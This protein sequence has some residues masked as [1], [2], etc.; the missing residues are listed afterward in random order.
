VVVASDGN[1]AARRLRDGTSYALVLL[2][3]MMPK[4]TGYQLLPIARAT[5]PKARVMLM[6]G[7]TDVVRG[8][9]GEDEP[10]SFLEK[11]FTAK[12]MDEAVDALL[13][14]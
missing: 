5:Q 10:D 6:S 11:P 2:D 13:M 7:Y 8:T 9:G 3:V 4:L 12:Q 14:R 1:E